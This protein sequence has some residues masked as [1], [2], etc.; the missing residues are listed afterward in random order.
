MQNELTGPDRTADANVCQRF[1]LRPQFEFD[2]EPPLKLDLNTQGN[3]VSSNVK[4]FS[5]PDAKPAALADTRPSAG[6]IWLTGLSGAGKS[7]LCSLASARLRTRGYRTFIIDGDTLRTGLNS[8]LGFSAPD[9]KESV[10]RAAYTAALLADAGLLVLVA[11]I[12]PFAA[13]RARAREIIGPHYHEV[14][15]NAGIEVCRRRDPKGL[16]R[17]ALNGELP[18]F[19]GV[20]SPYEAPAAP[21]LMLDSCN[22]PAAE[23]VT[24]LIDY[25]ARR[26]VPG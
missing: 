9:R 15:V 24:L 2:L 13:D 14:F 18:E 4:A 17:R 6:V 5:S 26:F 10:R 11:L 8:D 23:C 21:E 1:Q 3:R 19:T 7:T 12:A 16:Y 25:I 22:Q 20:S